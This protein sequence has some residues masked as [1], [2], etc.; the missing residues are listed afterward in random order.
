MSGMPGMT[1]HRRE[2]FA[3][4]LTRLALAH[5]PVTDSTFGGGRPGWLGQLG[6]VRNVVRQEIISRQ[7][8]KHLPEP[9]A[10]VLDVGAGQGTQSIR[11][12]RVGHRV[13]AM[14]PDPEMP[15]SR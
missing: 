8:D 5:A 2:S 13:L 14:E 12:A 15:A 6:N 4:T 3:H 10:R 9:P 1:A 7:L 11:L